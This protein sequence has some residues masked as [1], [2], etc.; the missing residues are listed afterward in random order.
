M[1]KDGAK[2]SRYALVQLEGQW[3]SLD[4]ERVAFR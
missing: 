1:P 4:A 2:G 3:E